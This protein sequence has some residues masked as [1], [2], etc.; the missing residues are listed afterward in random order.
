MIFFCANRQIHGPAQTGRVLARFNPIGEITFKMGHI[1]HNPVGKIASLGY[2]QSPQ[3]ADVHVS[4]PDNVKRFI[5][6]EK[7]HT[8][9]GGYRLKA[10]I[11]QIPVR[12]FQGS[13][14]AVSQN[15]VFRMK[16][17]FPAFGNKIAS[18]SRYAAAEI[19]DHTI[20]EFESGAHGYG[21]VIQS[22]FTIA[23][24]Y[25]HLLIEATL[26]SNRRRD[27][28]CARMPAQLSIQYF[29][30]QTLIWSQSGR[31]TLPV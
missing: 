29:F 2:F 15:A 21:L 22:K 28:E 1:A 27:E 12:G 19:H 7:T 24:A 18:Q 8:G 30:G 23:H 10:G 3:H 26:G 16:Q 11:E 13:R 25:L 17:N 9:K 31:R 5:V 14:G 20:L 4:A 6:G